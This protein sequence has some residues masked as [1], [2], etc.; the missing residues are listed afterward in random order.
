M[1]LI[2]AFFDLAASN[3]RHPALHPRAHLMLMLNVALGQYQPTSSCIVELQK[4]KTPS[5]PA[6]EEHASLRL[7]HDEA[8]LD[9]TTLVD[10][11]VVL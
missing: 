5:N 11:I 3:F 7:P 6:L 4:G 8:L 10:V 2:K 9:L 1:Q